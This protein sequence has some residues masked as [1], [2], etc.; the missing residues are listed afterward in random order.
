MVDRIV[1]IPQ[2]VNYCDPW[3]SDESGILFIGIVNGDD[4]DSM[5]QQ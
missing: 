1:K 4:P 2:L 3:K 5:K